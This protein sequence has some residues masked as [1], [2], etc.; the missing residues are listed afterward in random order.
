VD[1][2]DKEK[3]GRKNESFLKKICGKVCVREDE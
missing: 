3:E 1:E 2:V